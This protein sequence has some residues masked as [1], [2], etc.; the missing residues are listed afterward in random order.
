MKKH[1]L[2]TM[3]AAMLLAACDDDDKNIEYGTLP[4]TAKSFVVENFSDR[5]VATVFK[6]NEFMDSEY[7][8]VF[9]DGTK[10]NFDKDGVWEEVKTRDTLGVPTSIIPTAI[11]N[12]IA[13]NN[14][15]KKVVKI[16]K[17]HKGFK[18]IGIGKE[19]I[20]YE[21]ELD[22]KLEMLFDASGNLIRYDD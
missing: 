6:D 1:I 5:K 4:A 14:E 2:L 7:E 15:G 12:Y 11:K 18:V 20:Y 3:A 9:T 8:I 10:I 16:C 19:D 21:I 13:E 17:E 22:N